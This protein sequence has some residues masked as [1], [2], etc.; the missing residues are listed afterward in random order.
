MIHTL[1]SNPQFCCGCEWFPGTW[2]AGKAGM[3]AAGNLEANALASTEVVGSRPDVDL[4]MQTTVCLWNHTIG[5]QVYDAIAQINQFT[6]W[7]YGAE[8]G[9]EVGVLQAGA[10]VKIG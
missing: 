8:T 10:N 4:D 9:E 5:G 3:G 7:L 1:F 2:I 6:R